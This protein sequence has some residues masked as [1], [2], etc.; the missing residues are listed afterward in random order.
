MKTLALLLAL[1]ACGGEMAPTPQPEAKDALAPDVAQTDAM[2]TEEPEASAN[3]PDAS[4][5]SD[6]A[7]E[8]DACGPAVC[9]EAGIVVD[10]CGWHW[11]SGCTPK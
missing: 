3:T 5:A 7:P 10:L 9:V 1:T 4:D 8:L 11:Q 6:A 2:F